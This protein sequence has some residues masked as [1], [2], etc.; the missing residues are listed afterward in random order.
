MEVAEGCVEDF[1]RVSSR[2]SASKSLGSLAGS[3][4][5]KGG[6]SSLIV[7]S[8][9]TMPI[10]GVISAYLVCSTPDGEVPIPPEDK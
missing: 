9:E 3:E 10:E 1:N 5:E 7:L 6:G 2:P 8:D 4:D